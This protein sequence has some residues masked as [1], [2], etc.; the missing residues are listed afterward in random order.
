MLTQ[1]LRVTHQNRLFAILAVVALLLLSFTAVI[2]QDEDVTIVHAQGETVVPLNPQVVLTFDLASLSTLHALGI[3][4]VGVPDFLYPESLAQ[5]AGDEYVKIGSLFEPDYEQVNAL[6]PDL[7][8][9]AARSST[10]YPQLSEIAPTIDLTAPWGEG[11]LEA[12]QANAEIIGQIFDKEEEVAALWSDIEADIAAV[13][14]VAAEA[15]NALIILTSGGE[16]TA[17]GGDSR[18]GWLHNNL[19]FTPVFDDIEAAT[20]GEAISFEFILEANPDWLI[21][22]DRDAA[23]GQEA[24]A[25]AEVLDNELV[26]QTTAWQEEQVIYINPSNWYIVMGGLGAIQEMVDEIAVALGVD[27]DTEVDAEATAEPEATEASE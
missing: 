3:E 4:V 24:D 26:A 22:V 19:G 27:I 2:A 18:F 16:V 7:I 1:T 13:E 5:Y 6:E 12:Q 8:I 21:V 10:V 15:G 9:V 25:A 14:E 20:H 23:I 11:Y 17:Y